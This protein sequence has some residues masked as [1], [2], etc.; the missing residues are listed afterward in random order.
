M[1]YLA[2]QLR[3]AATESLREEERTG[4]KSFI[5]FSP[6]DLLDIVNALEEVEECTSDANQTSFDEEKHGTED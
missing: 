6:K 4:K 1:K 5:A 2:E 3:E